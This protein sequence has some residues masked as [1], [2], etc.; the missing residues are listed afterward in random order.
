AMVGPGNQGRNLLVQCLRAPGVRFVAVC[1]IWPYAQEYAAGILKKY[2]QPV[3]TYAD[4]QEM[5]EKEKDLDAVIIATPDWMHAPITR[6]CL[7]AGKHVYCEKEMSNTI[8]GAADMVKAAR[9]TKKL[10]QIGHQ[11]RS[12]PRY[13]KGFNLVNKNKVVGR[14]THCYG[15]WNRSRKLDLG[16]PKG[17]ELDHAALE[18]YGYDTMQRFRKWRWYKKFAGGPIAD[19][20]SHQV[21]IFGWFLKSNPVAV[22][23]TGGAD[24]YKDTEWYDNILTLYDFQTE[25]GPVRAMYQVLN[26]SSYGGYYEVFMGD[27]A[28][29][30]ISEDVN[31]GALFPEPVVQQQAWVDKVAKLNT[32][33]KVTVLLDI[34]ETLGAA[35]QAKGAKKTLEAAA[36]KP[37]HLYHLENFFDA[38]RKGTPLS[39][40]PEVAFET[41]VAVLRA[42]EALMS[43]KKYQFDPKEFHV[44]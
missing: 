14:L 9:E 22:Q 1:D 20:G 19:L 28:A 37:P 8:E 32:Q 26:T 44:A 17:R 11:R 3:H 33:G 7:E 40:P 10:L 23:A 42:N 31:R 43:G 15:Q 21:D 4:Y 5:L 39:C 36:E 16:W 38:I 25:T 34:G 29:L 27:A 35:G 6:A 12:N 24:Y 2:D 18:K 41:A 13:H 30:E